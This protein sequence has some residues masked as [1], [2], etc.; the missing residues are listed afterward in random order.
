VS[1]RINRR[2]LQDFLSGRTR[3]GWI[4]ANECVGRLSEALER[5]DWNAASRQLREEMAVRRDITPDALIPITETLIDQAEAAGC[6]ARFAGAG[7]G[8]ALW[9]LGEPE[10]IAELRRTWGNTLAPVSRAGILDCEVDAL[11]VGR[12]E[13]QG[14]EG[15]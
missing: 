4:E 13:G 1:S 7:G 5:E 10:R 15:I 14:R 3:A 8:G 12:V 9:A 6:G 11:G 2:W